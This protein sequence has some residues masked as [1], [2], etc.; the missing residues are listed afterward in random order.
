MASAS[1]DGRFRPFRAGH[2]R[3]AEKELVDKVKEMTLPMIGA[4]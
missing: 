3:V 1:C 2:P 4:V